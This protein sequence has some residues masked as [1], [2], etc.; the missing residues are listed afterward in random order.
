MMRVFSTRF[1]SLAAVSTAALFTLSSCGGGGS[2]GDAIA[3]GDFVVLSTEPSDNGR[4]FLND[5]IRID[6][7]NPIDLDSV[8]L[9]TFSFQVFDQIGDP[10]FEPV[11]GFFE[12][13]TSPGDT[14]PGRRLRF[15]PVLPTNDLY[16]N[17]GFRPG[18]TYEVQLVGGNR[19]NGTVIRDTS[20]RA[21]ALPRSF[22]FQTADGTSPGALF[23]DTASGGPTRTAFEIS[24]TP[25]TTG[26]VLNKLGTTPLELRLRFNQPLNPSSVNVPVAVVTDPELRN[27]NVRGRVYLEYDDPEFGDQE[28]IPADAEL[29]ENSVDGAVLVLRPLGVLPNNA[30][31]RVIVQTS[32]E[33]I[34]GES[35]VANVAY[36]PV[37]ATFRTQRAYEPQ[38]AGLVEQFNS[39]SRIDLD[40][41]FAEPVAEVGAGFVRGSF[42]FEGTVTGAEFEPSAP[43]TILNTDFTLVTPKNGSPFNVSGGVFN[44]RSVNIPQGRVVR[45]VGTNPMVWLVGEDFTVSGTLSVEGGDGERVASSSNADVPKAGGA[46]VCGGGDGGDGSPGALARD[47]GGGDGNGPGQVAGGGGGGGTLACEAGCNRGSGGGGGSLATQGDPFFK[48]EVAPAGTVPIGGG[49]PPPLNPFPIFQQQ[50]GAG[51]NGCVGDAGTATRSVDGGQSGATVFSDPR[52]DN[53]FWGSAVRYFANSSG[54][55]TDALR[56]TG[57]LSA[58]IGGGGGGGGGDL[59]YNDDC[60]VEEPNFQNDSSGGGGGGGGGVLIVKALGQIVINE[61]GRITADGGSGGGGEPSASSQ[62]GGGGGGGAGGMVILMSAQRIVI[63]TQGGNYADNNYDFSISADGGVCVSGQQPP[64]VTGKYPT[65]GTVIDEVYRD[66]YDSAPLGGFG[67]MGIVQLMA[68]PG[69][70]ATTT[71]NTNTILDDNIEII[72]SG[73]PLTGALKQ[74]ALAWRGFPNVFGQGV[75]DQ[76]NLTAIGDDEGEIRPAPVLLPSPFAS[77]SRIRSRWI[78]TGATARRVLLN[79]ADEL[80]RGVVVTNAN[81]AGP[82]YEFDGLQSAAGVAQG[83]ASFDVVQGVAQLAFP[84]IVAATPI[85]TSNAQSSFLGEVAY[86]VQ[87]QQSVLG[88]TNDRFVQYEAELLAADGTLLGSYR[89]L[90]HTANELVLSPESGALAT[91]AT[92]ARVMA[93]FYEVFTDGSPGLGG[94]YSGAVGRVPTANVRIGFAF[95]TDPQQSTGRYPEDGSFLF[96]LNDPAVQEEVRSRNMPFVQWDILFDSAFRSTGLDEPPALNPESPRPELRFLRLPFRF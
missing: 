76:G 10:V 6:F 66:N 2:T 31:V 8:D 20:G 96:D 95:H 41:A 54:E 61:S 79:A 46:G 33:D 89:I 11:A 74:A 9:S 60:G 29:E 72:R 81:E 36:E 44:F 3:G 63:N 45:G 59:S 75:D 5:P 14:E 34:A 86:R 69:D 80:P 24:P 92:S 68:P 77:R 21:L 51:G 91:E 56:I 93:K 17:G 85:L 13:G 73:L 40:A 22:R 18:R 78:D 30:T 25:D 15:V 57:E 37:F 82:R 58:P 53:N 65:S 27:S 55:Y 83:Y 32:L 49:T 70:P 87:L 39:S 90:S 23:R 7:S 26:V 94:T 4:L 67:G 1:F 19:N 71:D 88:T 62:Q 12:L 42:A 84:E 16:T 35:N 52:N 50:T 43:E 64:V 47:T 28:W 38:F 48:V